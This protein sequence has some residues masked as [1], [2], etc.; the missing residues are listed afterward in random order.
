[1]V[2]IGNCEFI[3][4]KVPERKKKEERRINADLEFT[5][6]DILDGQTFYDDT[7]DGEK[8]V[9]LLIALQKVLEY[10]TDKGI[11]ATMLN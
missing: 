3:I 5:V 11:V 9:G 2:D 7:K 4:K 1:M 6:D 8:W 10:A